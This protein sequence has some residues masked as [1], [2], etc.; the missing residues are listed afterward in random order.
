[1]TS[2][3]TT[4]PL[5]NGAKVHYWQSPDGIWFETFAVPG[6]QGFDNP[7]G[8]RSNATQTPATEVLASR[9]LCTTSVRGQKL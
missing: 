6:Y 3:T 8:N 4:L 7:I 1:M 5:C 2:L 9:G